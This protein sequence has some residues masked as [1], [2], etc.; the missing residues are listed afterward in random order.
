MRSSPDEKPPIQNLCV[1]CSRSQTF[2]YLRKWDADKSSREVSSNE[3]Q[4]IVLKKSV[5][6]KWVKN[7]SCDEC[8]LSVMKSLQKDER[9]KK[10]IGTRGRT[11]ED[12]GGPSPMMAST[13]GGEFPTVNRRFLRN[14]MRMREAKSLERRSR[15]RFKPRAFVEKAVKVGEAEEAVKADEAGKA[16]EDLFNAVARAKR[17]RRVS[18]VW[19]RRFLRKSGPVYKHLAERLINFLSIRSFQMF[20][21]ELWNCFFKKKVTNHMNTNLYFVFGKEGSEKERFL[22][23]L[24]ISFPFMYPS[25]R[26]YLIDLG[27]YGRCPIV[28]DSRYAVHSMGSSRSSGSSSSLR[29]SM[30]RSAPIDAKKRRPYVNKIIYPNLSEITQKEEAV[31]RL[32]NR[33]GCLQNIDPCNENLEY[34]LLAVTRIG[35]VKQF[36][37]KKELMRRLSVLVQSSPL[38]KGLPQRGE[39]PRKYPLT[40]KAEMSKRTRGLNLFNGGPSFVL[41]KN[42]DKLNHLQMPPLRRSCIVQ[43]ILKYVYLWKELNLNV[44]AFVLAGE[45]LEE[46]EAA[47]GGVASGGAAHPHGLNPLSEYLSNCATFEF[48]TFEMPPFLREAERHQYLTHLFKEKGVKCSKGDLKQIAEMT[49]SFSKA[50]LD[51][52]CRDECRERFIHAVRGGGGEVTNIGDVANMGEV[53]NIGRLPNMVELSKGLCTQGGAPPERSFFHK[54]LNLQSESHAVIRTH[55][56]ELYKGEKRSHPKRT[57]YP[58]RVSLLEDDPHS[59]ETHGLDRVI[60]EEELVGKLR[61]E[62]LRCFRSTWEEDHPCEKDHPCKRPRSE[63]PMG[64]LLYGKSGS[65]KT[66][67]AQKIIEECNCT[68]LVINCSHVFNK[69]MGESEKFLNDVFVYA[70]GRVGPCVILFDGIENICYST[71]G[72]SSHGMSKFTER[73]KL[74]F[75]QHLD[76]IHF[77][78]KW[79]VERRTAGKVFIIATTTEI[80]NVDANLM[81]EHR[82]RHVFCTKEFHLWRDSDVLRLVRTS[83]HQCNVPAESFVLSVGFQNFFREYI[84]SRKERLTPLCVSNLCR[85]AVARRVRRVLACAG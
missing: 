68:S 17:Y 30:P 35:L 80:T 69:V 64:I 3:Y 74:C 36:V 8:H 56:I 59:G 24:F 49:A 58:G 76:R 46:V 43:V 72:S 82:L 67:I 9:A 32:T 53:L 50:D 81:V 27:Q 44:H 55:E 21:V 33:R 38:W 6:Y 4:R 20:D 85:D 31:R 40:A 65:G 57:P 34:I 62:V 42:L 29:S 79:G 10:L 11:D 25:D 60:G 23:D 13:M 54:T 75:Y 5:K 52:L 22:E 61:A 15:R 26:V 41:I 14:E 71:K 19:L 51:N 63:P 1:Y 39:A 45:A 48:P 12:A 18:K 77:Q 7:L 78:N 47:E 37:W 28:S 84:L 2:S 66:F 73:L 70:S 83:L 16:Q